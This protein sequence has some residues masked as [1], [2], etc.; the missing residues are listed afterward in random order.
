MFLYDIK[1]KKMNRDVGV[2]FYR[3]VF[4]TSSYTIK[5]K[6]TVIFLLIIDRQFH[7]EKKMDDVH[8]VRALV[9]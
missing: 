3:E 8:H 2:I 6:L 5:K 7:D 1:I 4:V 9:K